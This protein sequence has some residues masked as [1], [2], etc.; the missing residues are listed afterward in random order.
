MICPVGWP[1][2][3]KAVLWE[4]FKEWVYGKIIKWK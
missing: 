4:D 1:K 2:A 3:L